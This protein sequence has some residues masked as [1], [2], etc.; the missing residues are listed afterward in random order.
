[1]GV[2]VFIIALCLFA[3]YVE[4][5]GDPIDPSSSPLGPEPWRVKTVVVKAY[6]GYRTVLEI[7]E[8]Y[9]PEQLRALINYKVRSHVMIF[10][11][12]VELKDNL[13]ANETGSI[14]VDVKSNLV[15]KYGSHSNGCKAVET[16]GDPF[17]A[18]LNMLNLNIIKDELKKGAEK[19][20]I[21][22]FLWSIYVQHNRNLFKLRD[23]SDFMRN[24]RGKKTVAYEHE[25][26]IPGQRGKWR[27]VAYFS[28]ESLAIDSKHALPMKLEFMHD[29]FNQNVLIDY[30]EPVR[31][32]EPIE[33]D[34]REVLLDPFTLQP[35]GDCSQAILKANNT[36]AIKSFRHIIFGPGEP[37]EFP[38]TRFSFEGKVEFMQEDTMHI[39][40]KTLV[41]F[42]NELGL[43]RI[44][45]NCSTM[46][47]GNSRQLID[48][49]EQSQLICL[50]EALDYRWKADDIDQ[51]DNC[52]K[53]GIASQSA[54]FGNKNQERDHKLLVGATTFVY[55]G[56]AKVRGIRAKVYEALD[57]DM[58]FWLEQTLSHKEGETQFPSWWTADD[59]SKE[60]SD[61]EFSRVTVLYVTDDH[62]D[63]QNPL[64][65]ETVLIDKTHRVVLE[66]RIVQIYQF[67]WSLEKSILGGQ[68]PLDLFHLDVEY[69]SKPQ[70]EAQVKVLLKPDRGPIKQFAE[71]HRMER[72]LVLLGSLRKDLSLWPQ[73]ISNF[74]SKLVGG[75]NESPSKLVLEFEYKSY[76]F[77]KVSL[78]RLGRGKVKVGFSKPV[79]TISL[80]HCVV[81]AKMLGRGTQF[82]FSLRYK[83]CYIPHKDQEEPFEL[84]LQQAGNLEIFKLS[85][86]QVSKSTGVLDIWRERF[87][88][89]DKQY[90]NK[91]IVLMLEDSSALTFD[92]LDFLVHGDRLKNEE[93]GQD[94][95]HTVIGFGLVET[96]GVHDSFEMQNNKPLGLLNALKEKGISVE[97]EDA[98]DMT[99]EKCY[100]ACMADIRCKSYSVCIK[101]G[102]VDCILS[103]LSPG[104]V[105]NFVKE[106]ATLYHTEVDIALDEKRIE[107]V[108]VQLKKSPFCTIYRKKYSDYFLMSVESAKDMTYSDIFFVKNIEECA[109]WCSL[110]KFG[111][112]T[113]YF[114]QIATILSD[115]ENTSDQDRGLK[116]LAY[117]NMST[118][119]LCESILY[120]D[121]QE[122][123]S[124]APDFEKKLI[125]AADKLDNRLNELPADLKGHFSVPHS[126]HHGETDKP[127][128]CA[129]KSNLN[130]AL[131]F[132]SSGNHYKITRGEFRA[133]HMYDRIPGVSF[134]RGRP[135]PETTQ[136]LVNLR[137]SPPEQLDQATVDI[138][139]NFIKSSSNDQK[140]I[141]TDTETCARWCSRNRLYVFPSCK[142]FDM[143]TTIS[144]TG[145]RKVE[146]FLNSVSLKEAIENDRIDLV[147]SGSNNTIVDRR[148]Y[149]LVDN[150]PKYQP[151][152]NEVQLK[153]LQQRSHSSQSLSII[154][155]FLQITTVLLA[156]A[157]GV[158]LGTNADWLLRRCM[159]T[160]EREQ[161][162]LTTNK[163]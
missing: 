163:L 24:V 17:D 86:E 21:G 54:L 22:P 144:K 150:I 160:Q 117:G 138:L 103:P 128:F 107:T 125:E 139:V 63:A 84:G 26:N 110:Y 52:V 126:G 140:G 130:D 59:M 1:M 133:S 99:L 10:R 145:F 15:L 137:T 119:T 98:E 104:N 131:V 89:K 35:A 92:I 79:K 158:Y 72:N 129:I 64:Q 95:D 162:L 101:Y 71:L 50:E 42:D 76:L 4:A 2:R 34:L 123:I 127:N 13:S 57:A 121:R 3:R 124:K 113:D 40:Y 85:Q 62:V 122:L 70:E 97:N 105:S 146:C 112:V 28:E 135:S 16:E 23:I 115:S 157:S 14:F 155:L 78:Q 74:Q 51:S 48:F 90:Y 118:N 7:E 82:G 148:H 68:Q 66:R 91:Q 109:K 19:Y 141:Y 36:E 142:S 8:N 9:S 102:K 94:E 65:L 80:L 27:L 83:L 43:M 93:Q 153:M 73:M 108:R 106:S 69:H 161:W 53:V 5:G 11:P 55:L 18:V 12:E 88:S 46:R 81:L 37:P 143:I 132:T 159:R 6:N 30:F 31:L 20:M 96:P 45:Q 25:I 38:Q 61:I 116:Q 136:A 58:P 100:S 151:N 154:S 67:V 49:F 60:Y 56:R 149:E 111:S 87:S 77:K 32:E 114:S 44:D 134:K 39:A 156:L 47:N 33:E 41:A 147:E 29:Y 75:N 120:F 152:L